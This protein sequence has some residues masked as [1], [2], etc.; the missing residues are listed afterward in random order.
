MRMTTFLVEDVYRRVA[1]VMRLVRAHRLG[2]DTAVGACL[3]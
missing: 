3:V 2:L 1:R